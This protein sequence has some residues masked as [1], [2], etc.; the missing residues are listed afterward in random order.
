M[1]PLCLCPHPHPHA[2]ARATTSTPTRSPARTRARAHTHTTHTH[3]HA[4]TQPFIHA[5]VHGH[6]NTVLFSTTRAQICTRPPSNHATEILMTKLDGTSDADT[7]GAVG[8]WHLHSEGSSCWLPITTQYSSMVSKAKGTGFDTVDG[9]YCG[10]PFLHALVE[11]PTCGFLR[12]TFGLSN[13][14]GRE[15]RCCTRQ[16]D[17]RSYLRAGNFNTIADLTTVGFSHNMVLCGALAR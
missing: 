5:R 17:A 12:R 4:H 15:L 7:T 6:H 8:K 16:H 9:I 14:S 10:A 3:T 11:R 13:A 2:L 1:R